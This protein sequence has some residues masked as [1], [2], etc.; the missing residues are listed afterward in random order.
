MVTDFSVEQSRYHVE[1]VQQYEA[2]R[3]ASDQMRSLVGTMSWKEV[4]ERQYL[5]RSIGR[6]NRQT[7]LGPRS[8]RTEAIFEKF[9]ADKNAAVMRLRAVEARLADIARFNKALRLGRV[10][11]EVSAVLTVLSR[12]GVLGKNVHVVGTTALYAYEFMAAAFLEPGLLAT[13]DLDI[14]F[15]PRRRQRL[16]LCVAGVA[17]VRLLDLIRE[18][19]SSYQIV[20]RRPYSARNNDGFLVDL[21][22]CPPRNPLR[23]SEATVLEG[24]WQAAEIMDLKWLLNAPKIQVV[25]IGSDGYPVPI[26]VPDPRAFAIYKLW[27]SRDPLREPAKRTRDAEQAFALAELIHRRLPNYPFDPRCLQM[28]P[29]QVRQGIEVTLNPLWSASED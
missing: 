7:S 1:T 14:L 11:A 20:E 23:R 4:R 24:D 6:G 3:D 8:P 19:D 5:V 28:F 10:P 12:K 29:E 17:P 25:A 9:W 16:S 2:W 26:S 18:A 15:D 27:L 21:I 13:S 22:K